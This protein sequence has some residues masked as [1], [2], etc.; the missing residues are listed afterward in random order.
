MNPISLLIADDHQILRDT[1][2][3]VLDADP[4][5]HVLSLC[6]TGEEAIEAAKLLSPQLVIMDINLPGMSG[7]EATTLITAQC[8]GTKVLGYSLHDEP[9]YA[10]RMMAAGALGYVTKTSSLKE[11]KAALLCIHNNVRYLC[12]EI[13]P[14]SQ[15][16]IHSVPVNELI[17]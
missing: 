12:R 5:F 1:W 15:K 14:S 6:A 2:K 17:S 3:M 11:M 10:Q 9:I 7:I 8:P 16:R 13:K 4:A